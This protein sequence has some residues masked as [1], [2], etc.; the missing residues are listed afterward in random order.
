MQQVIPLMS[1]N[2]DGNLLTT[3]SADTVVYIPAGN[4]HAVAAGYYISTAE[5]RMIPLTI[6]MMTSAVATAVFVDSN[7]AMLKRIIPAD[8]AQRRLGYLQ[9][10]FSTVNTLFQYCTSS[11]SLPELIQINWITEHG[12]PPLLDTDSE[13]TIRVLAEFEGGPTTRENGRTVEYLVVQLNLEPRLR[14][15]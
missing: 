15:Q 10:K 8:I 11:G 7:L 13:D 6:G 12:I 4:P 2:T 14:W 9:F 5:G 3:A 1:A